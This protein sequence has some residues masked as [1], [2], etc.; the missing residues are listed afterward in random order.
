M[1]KQEILRQADYNFQRGNR[2]L[3]KRYLTDLLEVSPNEE[4]AWLLL[5]RV[6][7][8]RE[9]KIDC[10]ESALRINPNN[11]ESRLA[12][13]RLKNPMRTLHLDR[14]AMNDR[15]L[16]LSMPAMNLLRGTLI[17]MAILI[18]LGSTTYAI[19]RNNP[20]STVG[21]LILPATSIPLPENSAGDVAAQSRAEVGRSYPQY[22]ALADA[23]IAFAVNNAEAGM[24]G[25]PERPGA[26]ILPS[27]SI[28]AEA[29]SALTSSLPQP[30]SLT[31]M[32][33]TEQQA[34][35]WLVLEA[36]KNADLPVSDLQVYLR[37]DKIQ[38]WG[39]IQGKDN[40][41]SALI[42]GKIDVDLAGNP[43]LNIESMQ[44]GSQVIPD[45][46]VSQ[47]ESWVN[48]LIN[49]AINRNAPGLQIMNIN[50]TNGLITISGMR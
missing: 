30:G 18:G 17:A 7:D 38:V 6:V 20:D 44:I 15:P 24:D 48:Q 13:S 10:Y 50:I 33:L 41:T 9:R 23:L 46:F 4:A 26:Q 32:M 25:A 5:A 2:A 35:S 19:A 14:Q 34:T 8:G 43:N 31:S 16:N 45:I 3:A 22:S 11:P 29:Q 39:M 21:R 12:L 40:S 28:A 37:N 27:D 47:T 36:K 1:N 49:E 42:V